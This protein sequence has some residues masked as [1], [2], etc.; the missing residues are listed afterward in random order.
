MQIKPCSRKK[1]LEQPAFVRKQILNR[2][3][4]IFFVG[5]DGRG[6]EQVLSPLQNTEGTLSCLLWLQILGALRMG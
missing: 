2:F 4:I 3:I 5:V 6:E 1:V